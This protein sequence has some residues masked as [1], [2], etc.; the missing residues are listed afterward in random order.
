MQKNDLL[1]VVH[2]SE[3][4]MLQ[5]HREREDPWVHRARWVG[6]RGKSSQKGHLSRSLLRLAGMLEW[7]PAVTGH[8][9]LSG[10]G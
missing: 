8:V 7:K 6:T 4:G 5:S 1:M 9:T 3:L 2:H 10:P